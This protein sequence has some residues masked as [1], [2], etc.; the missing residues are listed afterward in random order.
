MLFSVVIPTYNRLPLIKAALASVFAQTFTDFE[1]IVVDDGSTD[2][3]ADYVQGLNAAINVIRQENRGPG[4]ARNRGV[5]EAQGEYVA[6]LDSDDL[7]FP[8]TLRMFAKA[9]A[10]FDAPA[11][12]GGAYAEFTNESELREIS[13]EAPRMY[14]FSDYFAAS[15]K[16]YFVGSGTCALSRE[17]V[18]R[19]QFLEDRLNGEDHDIILRMGAE[20]GFVRI[21][22][23]T[24]LAYRRHRNSETGNFAIGVAGTLRLLRRERE[25]VYPGGAARVEERRRILARHAR[26][27]ALAC[28]RDGRIAQGWEAY[29]AMFLWNAQSK[30]WPFALAFPFLTVLALLGIRR[31][32]L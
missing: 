27:T 14:R 24:M 32:R 2:G 6:F 4:A 25:G 19:A 31:V 15:R 3:T 29:R 16:P 21:E 8:W 7:W 26:P 9:I 11:I 17:V 18:R 22:R 30:H 28:L 1:I 5:R 12:L 13:D 23:P 10:E 20:P